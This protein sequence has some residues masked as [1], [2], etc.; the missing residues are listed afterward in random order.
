GD[1][2]PVGLVSDIIG[3]I[4]HAERIEQ[5]L[6]FEL[7]QPLARNHFDNTPEHISRMAV[8]PPYARLIG[9]RQRR[10]PV[11]EFGVVKIA[12]IYV[13]IGIELLLLA[14]AEETVSDARGVPQ[15]IPDRDRA[16]RRHEL[17]RILS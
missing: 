11:G 9:E 13:G 10:D 16:L 15:Q 14:L 4:G 5:S 1:A 7:I 17:E 3:G 2:W 8:I 6:L 12:G